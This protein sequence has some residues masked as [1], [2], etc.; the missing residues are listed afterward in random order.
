M[1]QPPKR[2]YFCI[3]DINSTCPFNIFGDSPQ[4]RLNRHGFDKND[5]CCAKPQFR[6]TVELC[7][8]PKGVTLKKRRVGTAKKTLLEIPTGTDM[9]AFIAKHGKPTPGSGV[10]LAERPWL[11]AAALGDGNTSQA[12]RNGNAPNVGS[13][14]G[15]DYVSA[16]KCRN[17]LYLGEEGGLF[18]DYA[19]GGFIF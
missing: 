3:K 6:A 9:S 2:A 11:G 14:L 17:I 13:P 15:L 4:I 18:C 5:T 8:L 7:A 1:D 19:W 16:L 12:P 10:D